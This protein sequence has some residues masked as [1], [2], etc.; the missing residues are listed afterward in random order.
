VVTT[1]VTVAQMFLML[2]TVTP[3]LMAW[4]FSEQPTFTAKSVAHGARPCRP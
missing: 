3:V 1:R 2:S 4:I